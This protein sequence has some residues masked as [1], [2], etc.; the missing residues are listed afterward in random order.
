M[1]DEVNC[2]TMADVAMAGLKDEPSEYIDGND[3]RSFWRNYV[4]TC[5]PSESFVVGLVKGAVDVFR[6]V[7][8]AK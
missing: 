1:V 6:A 4:E 3:I 7:E 8:N 2:Y 5:D